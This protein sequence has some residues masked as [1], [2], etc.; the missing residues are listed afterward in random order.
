MNRIIEKES[1]CATTTRHWNTIERIGEPH[2]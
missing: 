2:E 1:S